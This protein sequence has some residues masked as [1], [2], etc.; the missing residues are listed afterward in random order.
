[1]TRDLARAPVTAGRVHGREDGRVLI[2]IPPDPRTGAGGGG[3]HM[4][5]LAP[6]P[7][8]S[9]DTTA[10][11]RGV[12][13]RADASCRAWPG[14]SPRRGKLPDVRSAPGG[15]IGRSGR[16][17]SPIRWSGE[18]EVASFQVEGVSSDVSALA[19]RVL[20]AVRKLM[21]REEGSVG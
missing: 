10:S 21:P 19:S 13:E 5:A 17:G 12:T 4:A 6:Q 3:W 11:R 7:R 14:D 18:D 20:N 2:E 9:R 8:R 16:L 1:M 15:L